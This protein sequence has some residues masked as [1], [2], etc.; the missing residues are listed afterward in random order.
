M[1]QFST[2]Q[3]FNVLLNSTLLFII[4][5]ILETTLHECG[6]FAMA[7]ALKAQ[8]VSLHHNYVN[9]NTAS[10]SVKD[11][12]LV[13]SAGPLVS[14]LT[15][16]VFEL[17]CLWKPRKD[18]GF[19]F[20]NYMAIFGYIGFFGYLLIAPFFAG[21]DTGYVF[22]A[23]GLPLWSVITISIVSIGILYIFMARLTRNFVI[24]CPVQAMEL[25]HSRAQFMYALI[26]YPTL[27]GILVTTLMN[28]PAIVLL[29]LLAPIMRPFTILWTFPL[30]IR[31]DYKGI[32]SN[33]DFR[34]I[35]HPSIYVFLGFL[36]IIL[37]NRFLVPGFMLG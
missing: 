21:G 7:L 20:M 10:L 22:L 36:I 6:H 17:L 25:Q 23:W 24:M 26:F 1:K 5:N 12:I 18:L 35:N 31:K 3:Y 28:L 13:S 32:F 34:R 2:K 4:A 30:A 14:L 8:Q 16:I 19:M 33:E 27:I 9:F 15:G 29:S 11:R 37:I